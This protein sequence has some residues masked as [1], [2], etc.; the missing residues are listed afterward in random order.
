MDNFFQLQS[1]AEVLARLQDFAPP[2]IEKLPLAK[3]RNRV[4]AED[5]YSPEALP[6]FCRSTMDG[7]AVRASDT[8]GSS[9]S[10]PALLTVIGELQMG[11]SGVEYSLQPG[12]AVQIW[13]G[14]EL[15]Q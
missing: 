6:P 9:E 15:P 10:E 14:G 1:S 3:A 13:T 12:Q 2:G 8:F 5:I 4:L 7:F 11:E